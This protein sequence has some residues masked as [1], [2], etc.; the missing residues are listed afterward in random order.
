M[1]PQRAKNTHKDPVC[2]MEVSYTTAV[3]EFNLRGKTYYFCSRACREAFEVAPVRYILQN[4][5]HGV[6]S[7]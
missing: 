7:A 3:D 5:Q 6:W 1:K 4:R 2:G